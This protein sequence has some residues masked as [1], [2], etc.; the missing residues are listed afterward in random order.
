MFLMSLL[1]PMSS[2]SPMSLVSPGFN[3]VYPVTVRDRRVTGDYI[4][5]V[6]RQGRIYKGFSGMCD[7]VT[8]VTL[9]FIKC[10]VCLKQTPLA[11]RERLKV[12]LVYPKCPIIPKIEKGE[13]IAMNYQQA[14][15]EMI[16]EVQDDRVLR[17]LYQFLRRIRRSD[18][19]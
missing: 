14:I 19:E 16:Q 9:T 8:G 3:A 4:F 18:K 17:F 6:T 1:S 7:R 13:H 11:E 12:R 2:A 10:K 15:Y 5:N